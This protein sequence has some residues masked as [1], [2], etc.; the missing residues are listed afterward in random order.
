MI[1]TLEK[2]GIIYIRQHSFSDC[3]YIS[4][5][6]F[7]AFDI[8]NNIAFEYNG[9]QH[10]YPVDFAGKGSD[11]A[12]EQFE[13]TRKRDVAKINYCNKNNIPMI[14]IPYWEIDNMENYILNKL[15]ELQ[16]KIA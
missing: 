4:K 15:K 8:I 14:I 16:L 10:Y 5:L 1:K 9:E 6:K 7:D 11:W 12:L 3:V 13:L 2:I